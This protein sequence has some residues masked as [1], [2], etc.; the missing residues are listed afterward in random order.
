MSILKECDMEINCEAAEAV[1]TS[2]F[3]KLAK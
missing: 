3:K 1:H 2:Y